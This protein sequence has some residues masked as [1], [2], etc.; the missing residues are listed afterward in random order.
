MTTTFIKISVEYLIYSGVT[1]KL[2]V[3]RLSLLSPPLSYATTLLIWSWLSMLS[4]VWL[5]KK[6]FS[7]ISFAM[8]FFIW[9]SMR[10]NVDQQ[11]FSRREVNTSSY[12]VI[13]S[14]SFYC[15]CFFVSMEKDF[16]LF[17]RSKKILSVQRLMHPKSFF[18]ISEIEK[19]SNWLNRKLWESMKE[20]RSEWR[21][22]VFHLIVQRDPRWTCS[23]ICLV[24]IFLSL[25]VRCWLRM[26]RT[27][28]ASKIIIER[29][30]PNAMI[31]DFDYL[32]FLSSN[33]SLETNASSTFSHQM[34]EWITIYYRSFSSNRS[35]NER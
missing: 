34:S 17:R 7:Q 30:L 25:L 16:E 23:E 24:S 28:T 33:Y 10:N 18:V 13:H 22:F 3:G 6:R 27:M 19:I 2:W 12:L 4:P 8:I 9:V 26:E 32:L 29:L 35:W 1:R 15:D 20:I 14:L 21:T 31:D 11:D 5:Y